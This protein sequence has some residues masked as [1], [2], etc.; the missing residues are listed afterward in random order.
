MFKEAEL[1]L[2][3][4]A[5]PS[6]GKSF[7][8]YFCDPFRM[9]LETFH[10]ILDF[11]QASKQTRLYNYFQAMREVGELINPF[12]PLDKKLQ[13][14]VKECLKESDGHYPVG[15]LEY[16]NE[17]AGKVRVFAMVDF[18]TQTALK[19]LH[20]YIFDILA[21]LPNDGTFDQR[22]S[23]LRAAEK[24]KVSKVSF[25]YDLSAATD[26]LPLELQIGVLASLFSWRFAYSWADLLVYKRKYALGDKD[27]KGLLNGVR[28]LSYSVGQP[29]GAL[30]SWGMM[31]LTHHLIVQYA[32]RLLYPLKPK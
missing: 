11:L 18:W 3:S 5:S 22:A 13:P 15:R 16:K 27:S 31:A 25:G 7:L 20:K 10:S 4:K 14:F 29:M 6:F 30:S 21:Q 1:S 8:G 12:A 26:R 24:V 23:I 9:P 28:F 17:A 2:I 19:G 32:Y